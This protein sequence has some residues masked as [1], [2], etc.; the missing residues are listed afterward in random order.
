MRFQ[1]QNAQRKPKRDISAFW[2]FGTDF[3]FHL[4]FKRKILSLQ[5]DTD[6]NFIIVTQNS[7]LRTRTSPNRGGGGR[8]VRRVSRR[9]KIL[10]P[11]TGALNTCIFGFFFFKP[12]GIVPFFF[13]AGS[14]DERLSVEGHLRQIL[15][16]G[17]RL[18]TVLL[19][20]QRHFP[21]RESDRRG[22]PRDG[23]GFRRVRFVRCPG[24]VQTRRRVRISFERGGFSR[25]SQF[26]CSTACVVVRVHSRPKYNS[27]QLLNRV[28]GISRGTSRPVR[29]IP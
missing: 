22:H 13:R 24:R 9:R 7:W 20:G 25:T 6:S 16:P 23:S 4:K 18:R 11:R 14:A 3:F 17:R 10:N 8:W 5:T 2:V 12:D 26:F 15:Q 1:S 27:A 28:H 29:R 19:R 21:G